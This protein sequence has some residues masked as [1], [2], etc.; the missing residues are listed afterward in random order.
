[1]TARKPRANPDECR[2]SDRW[3]DEERARF[4]ALIEQGWTDKA[5]AKELMRSVGAARRMAVLFR[6]K[7]PRG[8]SRSHS[9]ARAA[10]T[11]ELIA[12]WHTWEGPQTAF[13]TAVGMPVN[14]ISRRFSDARK[15]GVYVR[16]MR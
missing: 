4:L 11:A 3:T 6:T 13:A 15:R 8:G 12:L 2:A 9:P 10:K 14:S 16:K 7:R 1:M 5:I